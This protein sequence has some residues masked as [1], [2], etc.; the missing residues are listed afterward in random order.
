MRTDGLSLPAKTSYLIFKRACDIIIAALALLV[1]SP[2][3][4]IIALA[5]KLDSPGPV[6]FSQQRVRGRQNPDEPHPERH[7]FAFYKFR[8]MAVNCDPALHRAYV[9]HYMNGHC[10]EINNGS[11]S[12]PVYK[13][14]H[15]PRITRVGRLLRRTSLDELPQLV[16]I[17]KGD[18][19]LVGPRPAL[20]YEVEQ[21]ATHHRLRLVPHAG[22]TG[23]WQVS[24][25][26][27]LSFEQMICL[28]IEYARSRSF[29]LDLEILVRTIPAI[30]S[31]AGAW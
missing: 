19:S 7:V 11:D 20:P 24:G 17:L 22:L 14:K 1:L 6:I 31:A 13:M 15:D 2:L 5:I 23:L 18:M 4:A 3:M 21:Y 12:M 26:T 29:L 28:D 27:T 9:T 10:A 30:L 25:R 8:S 16:N